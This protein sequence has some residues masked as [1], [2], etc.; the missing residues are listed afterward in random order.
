MNQDWQKNVSMKIADKRCSGKAH[1]QNFTVINARSIAEDVVLDY[2]S[3]ATLQCT[4]DVVNG[5]LVDENII[6]TGKSL[7]ILQH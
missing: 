4:L 5:K 6:V 3:K 2:G 1:S 7:P